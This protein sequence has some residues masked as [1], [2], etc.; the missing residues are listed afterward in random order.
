[1]FASVLLSESSESQHDKVMQK[2]LIMLLASESV[3]GVSLMYSSGAERIYTVPAFD[4]RFIFK[5]LPLPVCRIWGA[6]REAKCGRGLIE[7]CGGSLSS[8]FDI[9]GEITL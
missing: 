5:A 2:C 9:L 1:M 6:S 8:D 4:F 3:D 7:R